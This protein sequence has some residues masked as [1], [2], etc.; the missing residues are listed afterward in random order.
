MVSKSLSVVI[1]SY[2]EMANLQK[3]YWT[4]SSIFYKKTNLTMKLSLLMMG[5]MMDHVNS[6]K[7]IQRKTRNSLSWKTLILVKL[8]L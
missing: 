6:L 1:P 3:G 4:K 7:N 2:N 5:Q 8:E